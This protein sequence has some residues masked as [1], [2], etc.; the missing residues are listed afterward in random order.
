MHAEI[1][2]ALSCY[3]FSRILTTESLPET[4]LHDMPV[5]F[6]GP[7]ARQHFRDLLDILVTSTT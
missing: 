1:W 5:E 2:V 4:P 6:V 7:F 3:I